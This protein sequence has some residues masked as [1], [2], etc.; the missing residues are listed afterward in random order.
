[1]VEISSEEMSFSVGKNFNANVASS[2]D[3]STQ[4]LSD[5]IKMIEQILSRSEAEIKGWQDEFKKANGVKPTLKDM[6]GDKSMLV[7][8]G[9]VQAK[10]REKAKFERILRGEVNL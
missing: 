8:L 7:L 10:R 6:Q 5:K 2:G 4:G 3:A 1:V 9:Q